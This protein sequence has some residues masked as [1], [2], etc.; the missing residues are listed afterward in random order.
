MRPGAVHAVEPSAAG[1]RDS[2]YGAGAPRAPQTP[3]VPRYLLHHRHAPDECR[4]VFAAW[5]GVASPLRHTVTLGSC[6]TGG[7]QIWWTVEATD[8]PT[9]LALLP[10]YLRPR[11]EAVEVTDT[12]I[13]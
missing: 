7:H 5:Q 8:E 6:A 13:P 9:A 3:D 1:T 12:P 2:P 11:T 4:T 10:P